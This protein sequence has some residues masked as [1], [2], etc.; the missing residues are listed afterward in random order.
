MLL[1]ILF[2]L[3]I[4]SL[5]AL[6]SIFFNFKGIFTKFKEVKYIRKHP[7]RTILFM[8]A[9]T[10]ALSGIFLGYYIFFQPVR[11]VSAVE[12]V[13]REKENIETLQA[14]KSTRDLLIVSEKQSFIM[15]DLRNKD[16]YSKSRLKGT[17]N[18]PSEN[19][20]ENLLKINKD[21]VVVFSSK[22]NLREA[23]N[24][25]SLL[26]RQKIKRVYVVKDGYEGLVEAGLEVAENRYEY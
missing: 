2:V 6:P 22:E 13:K 20:D 10:T 9:F 12:L 24:V 19:I 7:S 21:K 26:A 18:L 5:L 3:L 8:A 15:Y 17:G 1:A 4:F 16:D 14:Q 25:A 11:L 23:K